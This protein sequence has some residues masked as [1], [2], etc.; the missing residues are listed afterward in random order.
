MK[1]RTVLWYVEHLEAE[2]KRR[3]EVFYKILKREPLYQ[4]EVDLLAESLRN[5]DIYIQMLGQYV[6]GSRRRS[7]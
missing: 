3:R 1:V 7:R 6:R 5:T 4:P 2:K